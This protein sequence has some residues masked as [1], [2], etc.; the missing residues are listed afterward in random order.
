L[1][2]AGWAALAAGLCFGLAAAQVA[3]TAAAPSAEAIS[4]TPPSGLAGDALPQPSAQSPEI[5]R[6]AYL[7]TAGDCMYCHSVPGGPP[8][9]GGQALQTP[10]GALFSPNITPDKTYGI[11]NWT[12]EQFYNAIHNGIGVGH[13]LL[14]FPRYLYPVMP[15]QDY[16]KLSRADVMAMR[17][18]M[19]TVPPA[20]VPD[21]PT[22]MHF[23]FTMR[24]GLLAW[25]ILFFNN[26]PMQYDPSWSPSVRNGAYLVQAL[27]HCSECH[28][29]RNLAMATEPSRFLAGGQ[30]LAQSW[31][32]PNISSGPDGVGTWNRD[33]LVRFLWRD[34]GLGTGS[35]YG[36]MKEVVDDSLSRLPESDVQD[37]AAYLQT[38]TPQQA[39]AP[40]ATATGPGGGAAL[41]AESCAR[42]HGDDGAG[43]QQNFPNLAGNQSVWNGPASDVES[44]I[45]GGF[46]PWHPDQSAMPGFATTLSDEQVA[47]IANYVRTAWGNKGAAD[48]TASEVASERRKASSFAAL[49]TGTVQ[50]SLGGQSFDEVTGTFELFG[51]HQNCMLT[52]GRLSG[53]QQVTLAGGCAAQ[54]SRF[55]GQMSL[56]GTDYPVSLQMQE[57][58][59]G[60]GIA[61]VQFSGDVNGAPF[62]MRIALTKSVD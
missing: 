36:P 50:A 34:G 33:D 5:Q 3:V 25:R 10:F 43:V 53:A 14:V 39:S 62:T 27:G 35:A 54:G 23:P 6:G 59:A 15:W 18:Y 42:C 22:Q 11:G 51:D 60:Q 46:Q 29:E 49:S 61:A 56:D 17:A 58:V 20:A 28:T 7:V 24:A 52:N 44:M 38:A 45:L 8:F 4:F 37:I 30:I 31:Y 16:S 13:S 2:I 21:R 57:Q 47:A 48:A 26:Q 19:A 1:R 41:Y 55:V 12:D 9:A 40:P 32:A